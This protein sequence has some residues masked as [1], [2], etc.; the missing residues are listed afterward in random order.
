M[1][2]KIAES[3]YLQ[4]KLFPCSEDGN[5]L[6]LNNDDISTHQFFLAKSGKSEEKNYIISFH[7]IHPKCQCFDWTWTGQACKHI[8]AAELLRTKGM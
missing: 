1:K 2:S 3:L 7:K 5:I 4:H 8:L 6:Q